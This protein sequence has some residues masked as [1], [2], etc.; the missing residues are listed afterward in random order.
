MTNLT[1]KGNIGMD[2]EKFGTEIRSSLQKDFA[3]GVYAS[4]DEATACELD[5]LRSQ[6]GIIPACKLGCCHCCRYLI[7]TNIVEAR[8]LAQYIKLEF[9]SQQV[10]ELRIR[11]RQW[12]EWDQSRRAGVPS[13]SIDGRTDLSSYD[14]G[15]PLLVD[16]ACSAYSVRPVVCRTHFVNSIAL[17]CRSA[18]DPESAEDPPATLM[19]VVK[20]ASPFAEAVRDHIEKMGLDF[21]RSV[22]LLPHWLAI[23]MGW[24]F[25]LSA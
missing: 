21:S 3:N 1:E 2:T 7:V 25:A 10:K 11:T 22:M 17:A 16:G 8:A 13:A 4:V 24:E 9:S 15:C 14:H 12:H 20:A 6:D 18:I 23:E 19:S 5:R